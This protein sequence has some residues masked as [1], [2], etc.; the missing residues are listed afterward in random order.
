MLLA[1]L[2]CD[3]G[4]VTPDWSRMITQPKARAYGAS[5][6]FADGRAMRTPPAGTRAREDVATPE[7][8][9]TRALLER[10][11]DRFAL[12]CA[13]CHGLAGDGDTPVA[14]AMQRRPPPSLHE[15][16]I[17]R[18]TPAELARVIE[19]G[20]GVMPGYASMLSRADRHAVLAYVRTL[21]LA[22]SLP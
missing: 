6:V 12:V 10:G 21:Q 14:R 3:N 13:T 11:R 8:P 9:V 19:R 2:G 1:L 18:L 17:V 4:E 15:A 7:A 5:D 16:R 20:Y 22:G